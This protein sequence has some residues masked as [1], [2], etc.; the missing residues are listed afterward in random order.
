MIWHHLPP[1]Q[2]RLRPFHPGL[3][4]VMQISILADTTEQTFDPGA[5]LEW[6]PIELTRLADFV[7]RRAAVS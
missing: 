6:F 2:P 3:G 5:K 4:G 7:G 1:L